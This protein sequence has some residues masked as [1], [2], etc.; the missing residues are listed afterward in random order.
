MR[1]GMSYPRFASVVALLGLAAILPIDRARANELLGVCSFDSAT[2]SFRGGDLQ[3][4]KCLLRP[5]KMGGHLGAAL[6][7]LPGKR[8]PNS[9][10]V[11]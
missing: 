1:K 4:A 9:P 11:S 2:L 8:P 5:T 6:T 3:Q 7:T 10:C